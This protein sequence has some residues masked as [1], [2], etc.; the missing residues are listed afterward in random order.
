MDRDA[1]AFATL[2]APDGVLLDVEHR[3]PDGAAARPI[4]GRAALEALTRDWLASTP[5]FR[6]DVLA[7]VGDERRAAK[8]WRYA[9]GGL[10]V[11]GLTWL[12]C[13]DGAIDRA[14][15]LFDSYAFL[16]HAGAS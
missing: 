10:E 4:V 16:R 15:V 14:L 13:S 7:V 5:E 9:I 12:D 11:E 3:T 8:R 1:P 2:F 6:Y